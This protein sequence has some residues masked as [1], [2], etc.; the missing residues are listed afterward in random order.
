MS[1]HPADPPD[2]RGGGKWKDDRERLEWLDSLI[3]VYGDLPEACELAISEGGDLIAVEVSR[4]GKTETKTFSTSLACPEHGI[5]IEELEPRMFSFNAP[6]GACPECNGLGFIQKI[7]PEKVIDYDKSIVDGALS[8][9]FAS[10]EY[11]GYY[12]QVIQVLAEQRGASLYTP[13][14]EQPKKFIQ[15]TLYGTGTRK[16]R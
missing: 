15:E 13:F 2:P 7:D 9:V 8:K 11:S 1:G 3:T 6:Y 16:L 14:G 12:R 4:D 10:M 5:S